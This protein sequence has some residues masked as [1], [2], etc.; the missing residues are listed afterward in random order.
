MTSGLRESQSLD[1]SYSFVGSG[2]PLR[3]QLGFYGHSLAD[4]E[5][6][7]E[8]PIPYGIPGAV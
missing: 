5:R 2:L 7:K 6:Y 3:M 1:D 8:V 4:L